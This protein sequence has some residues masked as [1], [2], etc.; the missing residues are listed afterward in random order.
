LRN[1]RECRIISDLGVPLIRRRFGAPSRPLYP[2]AYTEAE[3]IQFQSFSEQAAIVAKEQHL[4]DRSPPSILFLDRQH[5][6]GFPDFTGIPC[7][8]RK[9]FVSIGYDGK[10][11]R[12]GQRQCSVDI[13]ERRSTCFR[14]PSL[15]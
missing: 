10:I 7:S 5:L 3:R 9:L 2:Q 12:C 15:R 8:A 1:F 11:F 13:F 14:K 6:D 4:A